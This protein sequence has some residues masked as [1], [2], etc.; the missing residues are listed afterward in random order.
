IDWEYTGVN[1]MYFDLA[2]I[3]MEFKLDDEMQDLFMNAY[4]ENDAYELEKLEAYKMVYRA[5]CEEWFSS[6]L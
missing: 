3:C 2:C 4:F 1:D 5:L 6:N